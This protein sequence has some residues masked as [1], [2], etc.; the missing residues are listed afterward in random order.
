VGAGQEYVHGYSRRERERLADQANT[1]VNLLHSDTSYPSGSMVL[2]VGCGAGAQTIMLARRSLGAKFV[3]M[4]ISKA[5]LAAA[6]ETIQSAGF[7]NVTFQQADVYSMEFEPKSFD[8]VFACFVLEHLPRPLEALENLR[9]VLRPGG[10]MTVIEGDHG[11]AHFH[12]DSPHARQVIQCLIEL[13]ARAGGDSLIGRKLY[14]LLLE[15]GFRQVAVS[16]RTV[17]VDSSR[18]QLVEGFTRN[19]FTAMV[20]GVR[21]RAL[22]AGLIDEAGWERGIRDLYRTSEEGGTFCYTFFKAVARR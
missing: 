1:L 17:Y 9:Q 18:P 4:D 13:Q 22:G 6:R 2:E 7:Q 16:P 3:A 21:A 8:H 12:P 20:E 5:S 14:P 15:A 11:S 19:T 10:T